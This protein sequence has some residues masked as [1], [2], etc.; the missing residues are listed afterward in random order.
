ME[1]VQ[2]TKVSLYKKTVDVSFSISVLLDLVISVCTRVNKTIYVTMAVV[3]RMNNLICSF[4]A[5]T[6]CLYVPKKC[7]KEDE[8][9]L[10]R[11]YVMPVVTQ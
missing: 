11:K 6:S 5:A 3:N 1:K 9:G 2:K 7:M 4:C 10:V 8:G